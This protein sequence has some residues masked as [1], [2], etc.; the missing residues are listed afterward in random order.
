MAA[1]LLPAAAVEEEVDHAE[2]TL[3]RQAV[4]AW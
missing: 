2:S 1:V 4:T 3:W